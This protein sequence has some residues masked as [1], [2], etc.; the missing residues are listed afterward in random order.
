MLRAQRG[1]KAPEPKVA[2]KAP[3]P[4]KKA[5][6]AVPAG[7]HRPEAEKAAKSEKKVVKESTDKEWY[8]GELF[9]KLL[10]EAVK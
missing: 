6:E 10:K 4:A 7:N 5:K 3:E 2:V 1:E 9:A 8:E